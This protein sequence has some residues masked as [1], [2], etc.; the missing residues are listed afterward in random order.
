[1]NFIQ[2]KF[3]PALFT[4][5][6]IWA[7]DTPALAAASDT[8]AYTDTKQTLQQTIETLMAQNGIVGLSIALV[9]DQR[10]V[11][12][13]GF[14]YANKGR[15]VKATPETVYRT[16][17]ISKL[18]TATA[19]MQLAEQGKFDIDR[20]LQTYIPEFAIKTR[21]QEA[22]PVTPRQLMTH[23][24]GLPSDYFK[25][26]MVARSPESFSGVVDKLSDQYVAY[27]P[28]LILSYS[29]LAVSLLGIAIENSCLAPFSDCVERNVFQVLGMPDSEFASGSSA[30]AL[31]SKEYADGVPVPATFLRDVPAGGL[32]SNVMD[33]S[34]F[35]HMVF[36]EGKLDG[37]QVISST[38][39]NEM[40]RPQN[41]DT[42][43]DLDHRVGLAW[44]LD[45]T[46]SGETIAW[47]NGTIGHFHSHLATLPAHKL[48]VVVLANSD[49]SEEVVGEIA[50]TALN[51][52]LT[53]K[54][55]DSG[56]VQ[57]TIHTPK[58]SQQN[59]DFQG[60]YASE[61]FG[62]L[63]IHSSRGALQIKANGQSYKLMPQT[64]GSVKFSFPL[65]G[66]EIRLSSENISEHRVLIADSG[67]TGRLLL[68]EKIARPDLSRIW[69]Q[70]LGTYQV[71]NRGDDIFAPKS[72][73][74]NMKNGYLIL[75]IAGMP[76]RVLTPVN[77]TE[78]I[79]AGLGRNLGD[80]VSFE[81][82]GRTKLMRYSGYLAKR[83]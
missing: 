1:M 28:N 80:T 21:F 2:H 41:A 72:L 66:G 31:M 52:L 24:S 44:F 3:M 32:N 69:R 33:L 43:L 50:N 17:S 73:R 36:G 55:G 81:T 57:T 74:L 35:M 78:A 6:S 83:K 45:Q 48:G 20:P 56:L 49:D 37:K 29:N 64:D 40:L 23:H 77:A 59:L 53:E 14:G 26:F 16:G 18:F 9:D 46:A 7:F 22:Q 51:L 13:E 38:T 63:N 10:V 60:Y 75:N 79:I 5:L 11:W 19:A 39:L 61:L 71:T 42:A 58:K 65:I 76:E 30:S 68:G 82:R 4:V 8:S 12:S 34:R 27:P 54:I 62:L 25:G 67:K 47:H 15:Q 70:R